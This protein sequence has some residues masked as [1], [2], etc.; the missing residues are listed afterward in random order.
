M[1]TETAG[2]GVAQAGREG[3]ETVVHSQTVRTGVL[4]EDGHVPT[5]DG[6][7]LATTV[8][9][10]A[11]GRALPAV[12]LRTPYDPDH[13][14]LGGARTGLRMLDAGYVV[15]VQSVRG[16]YG[17]SGTFEPLVADR[18]DAAD[19]L[20]WLADQPWCNGRIGLLGYSYPGMTA[21]MGVTTGHPAV[22]AAVIGT[23]GS[24]FDGLTYHAPGVAQLDALFLWSIT[25]ILP[26]TVRRSGAEVT[27]PELRT[28]MDPDAMDAAIALAALPPDA[29]PA[30]REAAQRRAA[31]LA[32]RHV[33]AAERL[34]AR[35][36]HEVTELIAGY[37]PWVGEFAAHPDPTDPF[38]HARDYRRHLD[39]V[40]APVLHV[41]G[42][43][44]LF[45]RGTLRDFGTLSSLRTGADS[46]VV[47]PY[48]HLGPAVPVGEW[49][50]P[51]AASAD[52]LSPLGASVAPVPAPVTAF[53]D[54]HL[55]DQG[56][57]AEPPVSVYLQRGGPWL[58]GERWPLPGTRFE[59]W[60]LHRVEGG[61]GGLDR[62]APVEDERPDTVVADPGD[63][64]P[65]AGGTFLTGIR[66]AGVVDQAVVEARPDVLTYTSA[67]LDAGVDVAGP[68]SAELYV[69]TDAVDADVV[70]TL[71]DVAPDGRSLNVCSGVCRLRF[72][73]AAPGLA[74]PG[75]VQ[76]VDVALSPT[77]HRFEAGH[78]VR[79][80]VAPSC[81]P[82]F[83]P[84]AN[85]GRNPMSEAGDSV[86]ARQAVLHDPEHPSRVVLPVVA[87]S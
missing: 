10:P 68:V 5:R 17:S 20:D 63:P 48:T 44:D 78:R 51:L 60:Y 37:A 65:S 80:Q 83:A 33:R 6:E 27:D 40:R 21:W 35:P 82:L 34:L 66:P 38:W 67:R 55:R 47:T 16:R 3:L 71:A 25:Q 57:P 77:A 4:R 87:M 14:S 74:T 73:P 36:P 43:H 81:F 18:A 70:V 13:P 72:R 84:N 59:T 76:R 39:R 53:L 9:R 22:R 58:H 11:A 23:T 30:D 29:A 61:A 7:R 24:V 54:R 62:T 46:L 64:V 8:F 12:L 86:V 52:P 56:R 19:T 75:E 2:E 42:W 32:T 79:V 28:L 49:T 15:V 41:G 1:S 50:P 69:T 26:D 45:I 31:D 85:T